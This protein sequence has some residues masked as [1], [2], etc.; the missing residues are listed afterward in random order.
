MNRILSDADAAGF[1]DFS[2]IET[3]TLDNI[4]AANNIER[5]DLIKIDIEGYEMHALRGA[6]ATLTKFSPKLFIEVGYQRLIDLGTSPNE[7]LAFLRG[8]GY[9]AFRAETDEP[10]PEDFDFSPYGDGGFDV[11]AVFDDK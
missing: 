3:D 2:A 5:V 10:I 6:T 8:F 1:T 9:S 7:M 11:Y 4:V